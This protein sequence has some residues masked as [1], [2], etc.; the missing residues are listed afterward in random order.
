MAY[1]DTTRRYRVQKETILCEVLVSSI[2]YLQ[3]DC[4][5]RVSLEIRCCLLY[6]AIAVPDTI[7]VVQIKSANFHNQDA[8][9]TQNSY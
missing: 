3:L 2:I 8:M 4:L 9:T 6:N 5:N 1:G 7:Q